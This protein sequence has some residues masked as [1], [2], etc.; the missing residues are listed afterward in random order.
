VKENKLPL[1]AIIE[2]LDRIREELMT[3]QR[4]LESSETPV[5]APAKGRSRK[6]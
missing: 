6:V 1:K 2:D 5:P 4:K 3:I